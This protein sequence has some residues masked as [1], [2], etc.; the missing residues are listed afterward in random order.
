MKPPNKKRNIEILKGVYNFLKIKE[1]PENIAK[2]LAS[3]DQILMK[4]MQIVK[5]KV[6]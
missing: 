2:K 1:L 4:I 5:M 6:K 3:F